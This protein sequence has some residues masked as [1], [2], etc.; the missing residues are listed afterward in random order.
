VTSDTVPGATAFDSE[1][2]TFLAL[3]FRW[4]KAVSLT[5]FRGR[6]EAARLGV[7]PSLAA[8]HFLPESGPA[9]DV[10]S[11]GGFPAI[12]L[13]LARRGLRWTLSEPSERKSAF[14]R[15]AGRALSLPLDVVGQ[16]VE[17]LLAE[18][19]C[20]W[21]AITVRG[22]RLAPGMVG[23][24]ARALEPGGILLVWT[25]EEA[26][27]TYSAWMEKAG[28]QVSPRDLGPGIGVLVAGRAP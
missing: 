4:N 15:E 26:A 9:L 27:R 24:L 25:G 22:V 10:G 16:P 18:R 28:L 5:A 7:A 14:L 19:P 8:L 20:P 11:G 2:G 3:L 21:G 6:E 23:A 13:A 17:R 1:V 12:P